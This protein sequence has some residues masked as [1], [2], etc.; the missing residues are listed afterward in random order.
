[1]TTS[2]TAVCSSDHLLGGRRRAPVR[3]VAAG[4]LVATLY[5]VT[6]AQAQS[7][8]QPTL[9]ASLEQ[10]T[11]DPAE[12]AELKRQLEQHAAVL[13]AQA[14]VVKAIAKLVGPAVVSIETEL[15]PEGNAP[16]GRSVEEHGSGVIVELDREFYV[17]TAR[18]VVR[19]AAPPAVHVDLADGR[20]IH[21]GKILEDPDA[22]VAVLPVA[23][24]HLVAA[25]IG[26][27]DRIQVGDFVVAI[28]S[29]FG[30]R[31]SVTFG[32]LSARSRHDL[33][34]RGATIRFQDFL[35]TDA[36]MNPGNSGGPLLN[37]RGEVVGICTCIASDSGYNKGVGFSIPSNMFMIIARQLVKTGR[38]TR[39]FLGVNL[40]SKFG[41][42]MA[43]EVGLPRPVGALVTSV[44][45][46]SPAAEAGLQSGDVIIEFN[47]TPIQ[48]DAHLVN[49]VSLTEVGQKATL[50]VFRD[51]RLMT[52][53]VEVGDRSKF[54]Q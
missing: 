50:S 14:A 25:A 18:H 39:G 53:S 31:Q 11:P 41:P 28:G 42:A 30:L 38:V 6:L 49:V 10:W 52:L 44:T 16:G 32:I 12:R 20:R 3:R 54:G 37:L 17:L 23:A 1:M 2:P 40:E 35:Q 24:P 34:L 36:A 8:D 51:R 7:P 48:D 4:L 29:P 43:A 27:S 22:D 9:P 45:A 26:D 47:R 5:I 33:R 19:D 46:R 13:N 21:P 15:V